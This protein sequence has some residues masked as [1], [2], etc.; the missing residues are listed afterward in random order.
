MERVPLQ[1][2]EIVF[3]SSD[4][5]ISRTISSLVKDG[6]LRKLAPRIYTTNLTGDPNEI[7]RRNIFKIIGRLYPGALLSHRSAFEFKPTSQGNLF[8]TSSYPNKV[9]LPGIT[10]N[11]LKG[12]KAIEGD[13]IFTDGLYVS[14]QPRAF[15][16]NFEQTRKVGPTSKTLTV[17]ELEE[18][19]EQIVRVKGEEGLNALRD[20]ARKIAEQLDMPKEFGRLDRLIGAIL[21]TKPAH[22]LSS[23]VA[24]ARALG[25]PYDPSRLSLFE[26]LF[27]E[28]QQREF[29]L[30]SDANT[31]DRSFRNFAFFEA[32]FS[33]YIEG[34][35]FDVEEAKEI[36]ETGEPVP[37]RDEDSHD[38]LGTY[39]IVSNRREMMRT[40]ASTDELLH[41]LQ[42]RHRILLQARIS[43]NPG[44]FKDRNNQAGSTLFVEYT[45]V[46]GTLSR[47]F[48]FYRALSD[49]FAKA[50]YMMFMITE[51]HPFLDGNGRIARVMMN[52][53]LVKAS[54]TKIIIPTV[55]RDDYLS[56]LR[57]L[58]RRQQPDAFIRML[59]RAQRF[60][61]TITGDDM[62]AMQEKLVRSNAFKEGDEFILKIVS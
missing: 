53:E 48:D 51:V 59:Q 60:S 4:P 25:H 33:N 13:N 35:K 8:L 50:V 32:Y 40:P 47:G 46:R 11:F 1:T 9:R 61:A 26:K 49:P 12:H 58:T 41:I 36:I 57:R 7:I 55:Y 31:T 21:S 29:A 10:L 37:S 6:L 45:L 14:Q 17:P 27:V 44:E 16:E 42:Y 56:A 5:E 54:E 39:Q 43:K 3:S 34:T 52:A 19:L 18:K 38:I 20:Q 30:L 22:L 28:L 24:I 15:L 23:P 62:N 2:Q